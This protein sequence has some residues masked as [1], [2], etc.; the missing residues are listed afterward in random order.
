MSKEILHI[1]CRVSTKGQE[2]E[3]TS[4]EEQKRRGIQISKELG[5]G[6]KIYN[7]KGKSSNYEDFYGRPKI[8]DIMIGMDEGRIK[9][10]YGWNQDRISRNDIFW[11]QFRT[12]LIKQKITFYTDKGTYKFDNHND[13]LIFTILSSLGEHE[14]QIRKIRTTRG[15][16]KRIKEGGWMGGPSPFGYKIE[17]KK[18]VEDKKQSRWVKFIYDQFNKGKSIRNIREELFLNGIKT[19]RGNERWSL[20]SIESILKNQ[21]YEGRYK[22]TDH[23]LGEEIECKCPQILDKDTILSTR[24]RLI[25][26]GYSNRQKNSKQTH[27]Y[28][29]KG[30]VYCK[31]CGSNYT[32]RYLNGKRRTYYC[33]KQQSHSTPHKH[34]NRYVHYD[35]FN[36][37]IWNTTIETLM[38]SSIWRENQKTDILGKKRTRIEKTKSNKN[39]IRNIDLEI[40]DIENSI[41]KLPEM[42]MMN[43]KMKTEYLKRSEVQ[44]LRLNKERDLLE[45][46][47]VDFKKQNEWIDWMKIM[48]DRLNQKGEK[49]EEEKHQFLRTIID[50]IDIKIIDKKNHLIDIHYLLPIVKD[51]YNN[52]KKRKTMD[53]NRILTLREQI[54]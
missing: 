14:N 43:G 48:E 39:K 22:V 40:Q 4:L 20:G 1:Y 13:K 52:K 16:F 36:D 53:G 27:Y 19:N 7:E 41:L 21:H 37:L 31:E 2:I 25:Q 8:H 11:N 44:L 6:Y 17:D 18:L 34:D 23:E 29:L 46:E 33:L 49:T 5:M 35:K 47:L 38:N 26:R 42:T 45:S 28:M 24:K 54:T 9:H 10:L 3:G 12:I 30:L 50:R 32:G 15:K 51:R